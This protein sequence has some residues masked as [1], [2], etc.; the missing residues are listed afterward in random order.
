VAGVVIST[1]SACALILL[2][3]LA[4]SAV[5]CVWL[6]KMLA[7]LPFGIGFTVASLGIQISAEATPPGRWTVVQLSPGSLTLQDERGLRHFT[8]SN[9]EALKIVHD[10][11]KRRFS[12]RQHKPDRSRVSESSARR[13]L[14]G[15]GE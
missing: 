9:P 10:W 1:V 5:I 3:L 2:P 6:M 8:H 11:L 12:T 4:V 15:S 7:V 13:R 14:S